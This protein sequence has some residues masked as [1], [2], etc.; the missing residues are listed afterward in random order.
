MARLHPEMRVA[1]NTRDAQVSPRMLGERVRG[2]GESAEARRDTGGEGQRPPA[3]ES[4]VAEGKGGKRG[5]RGFWKE[6][7][8][9]V[10]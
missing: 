5:S 4:L 9:F 10:R 2:S 3:Y 7:K 1:Q 6:G 8:G